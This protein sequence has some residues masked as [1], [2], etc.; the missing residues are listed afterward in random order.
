MRFAPVTVLAGCAAASAGGLVFLQAHLPRGSG[1]PAP[2][3]A[4]QADE[5]GLPASFLGDASAGTQ[6]SAAHSVVVGLT[7]GLLVGLAGAVAPASAK[8]EGDAYKEIC[9]NPE[10]ASVFKGCRAGALSKA[11]KKIRDKTYTDTPVGR[12]DWESA[13]GQ[14][15]YAKFKFDLASPIARN[16]VRAEADGKYPK[17][18]ILAADVMT[19][20]LKDYR[21]K[22]YKQGRVKNYDWNDDSRFSQGS[23]YFDTYVNPW[24]PKNTAAYP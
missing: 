4:A 21:V 15:V 5:V 10:T 9:E 23:P 7:L 11:T 17:Q 13:T 18:D 22:L 6:G 12:P 20:E 3:S 16:Y 8:L 14:G 19:Q 1:P 24:P 2:P